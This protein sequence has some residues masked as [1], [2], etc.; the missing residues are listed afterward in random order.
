MQRMCFGWQGQLYVTR[1]APNAAPLYFSSSATLAQLGTGLPSGIEQLKGAWALETCK[2]N[3]HLT[4]YL[5]ESPAH[6]D[7]HAGASGRSPP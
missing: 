6:A 7:G 1:P 4:V 3:H 2:G 5:S